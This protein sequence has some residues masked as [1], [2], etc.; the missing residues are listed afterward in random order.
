MTRSRRIFSDLMAQQTQQPITGTMNI[1]DAISDFT[2]KLYHII[3]NNNAD[4]N[5]FMSP[6]SVSAALMLTMLGCS[7]ESESQLRTGLCLQTM[8][9]ANIHEEYRKIHNSIRKTSGEDVSL[10]VANRAYLA[11][12][13]TLLESYKSDSLEYYGSETEQLDFVGDKEGSRKQINAWAEQQT[14]NKIKDLIP[15][16]ALDPP[17]SVVLV[18]TNAIYFKGEWA[19]KFDASETKKREFHLTSSKSDMI[20]MM[21]MKDEKWLFGTSDKWYCKMLQL[22][23]KG[24]RISMMVILPN[25]IEGLKNVEA[26]LSLGMLREI[27][28]QMYEDNLE[29]VVLPKFEMEC[30]FELE[31]VLPQMGI[32]DIFSPGKANFDRMFED[33]SGNMAVSKV[34]HKA[35]VG[36]KEEGTEAA[37]ATALQYLMCCES[38]WQ[39]PPRMKFI[40]DHPFLFLIQENDNGTILFVGRFTQPAN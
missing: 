13:F 25:K 32:T 35:F 23:Y 40:A 6:Y 3:S 27:R 29:I 30:S 39:G 19:R 26:N 1:G 4:G 20:D 22:P 5:M 14:N 9:S 33:Q 16:G 24:N 38:V 15:P 8:P 21:H 12:G 18:L 36:V 2:L 31:K 17:P 28:L 7:G 37:A 11:L 34:I 10:S